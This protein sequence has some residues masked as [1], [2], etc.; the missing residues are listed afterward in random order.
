MNKSQIR[1]ECIGD[2]TAGDGLSC[3]AL[4]VIRHLTFERNCRCKVESYPTPDS[5]HVELGKL[6][7]E[8]IEVD[9]KV[10]VISI[11]ILCRCHRRHYP[12]AQHQSTDKRQTFC[13][14][15]LTYLP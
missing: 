3:A 9:S 11:I 13:F 5:E 2:A 15:C 12:K 6:K 1:A 10:A 7:P 8:I 4:E 14:H